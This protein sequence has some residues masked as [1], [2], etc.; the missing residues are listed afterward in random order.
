M[1]EGAGPGPSHSPPPANRFRKRPTTNRRPLGSNAGNFRLMT[2]RFVKPFA[3]VSF[4]LWAG[5]SA[6]SPV[7]THP[8]QGVT[9]IVRSENFPRRLNM[10]IV[11]IDLTAPG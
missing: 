6:A 3:L 4:L 10:H 5:L 8:Y 9:Y 1:L 2:L 11:V 7:M